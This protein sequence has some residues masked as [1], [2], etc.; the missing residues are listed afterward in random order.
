MLSVSRKLPQAFDRN[1]D[2]K[3]SSASS[4]IASNNDLL[5]QIFMCLPVRSLIVFKSVSKGWLSLISDPFFVNHHSARASLSI[6]GLF[7]PKLSFATNAE[8]EFIFL[9]GRKV[10]S[11]VPFR[12]LNFVNDPRGLKIERSCNGLLCCS[13]FRWDR[14]DRTYYIYNPST[15]LSKTIPKAH[16]RRKDFF[17]VCSVSLAFNPFKS[18]HYK[19]VCVSG[20]RSNQYQ[21]EIFDSKTDTWKVSGDPLNACFDTFSRPGVFWNGSLHWISVGEFGKRNSESNAF[22]YFDTEQELVKEIPVPPLPDN[23]DWPERKIGYFGEYKGHL[24]LV[25]IYNKYSTYIQ[26]LEMDI[27]YRWWNIKYRVD[28]ESLVTSYPE[29]I[30]DDDGNNYVNELVSLYDFEFSILLVREEEKEEKSSLVIHIP[31]KIICYKLV[32]LSFTKTHDLPPSLL[33]KG[34]IQYA[35]FDAHQY[36]ESLSFV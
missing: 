13:N 26:I 15:K 9:D 25:P 28:M 31:D 11:G 10:T 21:I 27:D 34:S 5:I 2:D 19:V 8:F 29:M 23:E 1:S 32:E 4:V 22:V 30:P 3:A 18:P 35:W 36:I 14:N 33:G 20:N 12:V 6:P 7:L 16:S 17:L 24:H